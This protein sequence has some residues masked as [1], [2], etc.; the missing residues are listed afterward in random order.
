M[1]SRQRHA[2]FSN[3]RFVFISPSV[4]FERVPLRWNQR[5]TN[6]AERPGTWVTVLTDDM[7]NT[8]LVSFRSV[9]AVV[10]APVDPVGNA[11]RCPQ[12]HGRGAWVCAVGCCD[13]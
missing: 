9:A 13:D 7:G 8:F 10:V 2:I 5:A 4:F 6:S 11:Q 3:C 1:A 12:V